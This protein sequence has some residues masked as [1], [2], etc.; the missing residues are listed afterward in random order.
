M[1]RSDYQEQQC[2]QSTDISSVEDGSRKESVATQTTQAKPSQIVVL[3]NY[4]SLR[5]VQSALSM[6]LFLPPETPLLFGQELSLG[7]TPETPGY[8][9]FALHRDQPQCKEEDDSLKK[10][11]DFLVSRDC[12]PVRYRVKGMLPEAAERTKR[13]H[14]RKDRQGIVAVVETIA[15]GQEDE[16]WAELT[17]SV[18]KLENVIRK[19]GER[20]KSSEW[21]TGVINLLMAFKSYLKDSYRL[22]V[23]TS[24]RCPD[25]C[26]TF[27]FSDPSEPEFSEEC[28]HSHDLVC[29]DCENL[30]H[31]E[32]L[33]KNAFSDPEIVFYSNDEK[34]DK[35]HDV[36]YCNDGLKVWKAYNI[37]TGK[38]VAWESLDKDGKILPSEIKIIESGSQGNRESIK[39][40][41]TCLA[42]ELPGPMKPVRSPEESGNEDRDCGLF[43]FPEPGCVKQYI[44]MGKLEKYIAAEKH[45]FQDV[46]NPLEIK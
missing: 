2:A 43:S 16:T 8:Q 15:P 31:L 40:E 23:S 5:R 35:L 25:H 30:Y 17:R 21:V 32:S 46:L 12:S 24:S 20:A 39:K 18:E 3:T 38:L 42:A 44:T 10:L 37:G 4:S 26:S 19:L 6:N 27:A 7:E 22:H 1:M 13:E 36:Q 9:S 11:N 41:N 33:M 34:E 14:L 29:N 45:S 28:D